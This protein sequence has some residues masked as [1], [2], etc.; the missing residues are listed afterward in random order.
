MS[1]ESPGKR[2]AESS[3]SFGKRGDEERPGALG[4][5]RVSDP[6]PVRRAE[7]RGGPL[8]MLPSRGDRDRLGW[9]GSEVQLLYAV[10]Y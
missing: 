2:P 10:V 3:G 7:G 4:V 1:A 9:F 8:Q 5:E 6:V